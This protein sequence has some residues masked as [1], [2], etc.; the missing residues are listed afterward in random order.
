MADIPNAIPIAS[1]IDIGSLNKNQLTIIKVIM[2]NNTNI[3]L[4]IAMFLYLKLNAK[5]NIPTK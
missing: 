5:N 4:A 3:I 2:L 1:F